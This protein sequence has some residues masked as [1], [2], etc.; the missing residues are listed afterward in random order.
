MD[1]WLFDRDFDDLLSNPLAKYFGVERAPRRENE[2]AV[3]R[4]DQQGSGDNVAVARRERMF[5]PRCD[6]EESGN[7]FV[8]R[9]ELPGITKEK[10]QVDYDGTRNILSLYGSSEEQHSETKEDGGFKSHFQERRYGSFKREF[11][12]PEECKAHV[13]EITAKSA[14]GILEVHCPKG[15]IEEPKKLQIAIQ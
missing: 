3:A 9:A 1:F 4:R 6:V 14:D 13:G 2:T 11:Q 15:K 5:R 8:V 10:V 7:E 12:L